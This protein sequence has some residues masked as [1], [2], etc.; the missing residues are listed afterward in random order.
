MAD[1][2]PELSKLE[3]IEAK[4]EARKAELA[5]KYNEQRA[6]DLE[7]IDELEIEHGDSNIRVVD[8]PFTPG[9]P[10]CFAGKCPSPDLVKRYRTRVS[11]KKDGSTDASPMAAAQEVG[12][13]C[14]VYPDAETWAKLLA[15]RPGIDVQ[16]GLEVLR[17]A[18]GRAQEEGKN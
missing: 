3:A 18:A 7:A 9:L 5:K 2:T 10:T 12:A 13:A 6:I 16:L 1:E 4:R 11:P 17:L 14:R 8:V 15:A